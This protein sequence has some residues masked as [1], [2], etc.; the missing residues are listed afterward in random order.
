MD[1]LVDAELADPVNFA[2]NTLVLVTP[3]G[4]PASVTGLADLADP[5]LTIALCD[6]SVPVRRRPPCS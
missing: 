4:N 1:R 2:S 6:P 5:S 3:A